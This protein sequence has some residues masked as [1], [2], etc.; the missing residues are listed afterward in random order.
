M[1]KRDDGMGE[2]RRWM[3]MI[4]QRMEAE[5]MIMIQQRPEARDAGVGLES[6]QG[7]FL[8]EGVYTSRG[9]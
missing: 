8:Y 3:M 7:V 1:G 2:W 4:Q 9:L 6:P 5:W